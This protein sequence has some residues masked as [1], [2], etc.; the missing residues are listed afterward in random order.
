MSLDE[1]RHPSCHWQPAQIAKA[2]W[3]GVFLA[4]SQARAQPV[5]DAPQELLFEYLQSKNLTILD[6]GILDDFNAHF[7]QV[8]YLAS[9]GNEVK[10]DSL[11]HQALTV[12]RDHKVAHRVFLGLTALIG[13]YDVEK[14]RFRVLYPMYGKSGKDRGELFSHDP[15][16]GVP[17]IPGHVYSE[18][19][20]RAFTSCTYTPRPAQ[21]VDFSKESYFEVVSPC[22]QNTHQ[23]TFAFDAWR[24][25]SDLIPSVF[26]IVP[27]EDRD[28]SFLEMGPDD[29]E[30]LIDKLRPAQR[31]IWAEF[32]FDVLDMKTGPKAEIQLDELPDIT[33]RLEVGAEF[34]VRPIAMFAWAYRPDYRGRSWLSAKEPGNFLFAKGS[35]KSKG[36][37]PGG[38]ITQQAIADT[39]LSVSQANNVPRAAVGRK[40][41]V[42]RP[43]GVEGD[44]PPQQARD[45][46]SV[47]TPAPPS[48]DFEKPPGH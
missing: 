44:V 45:S 43:G 47:V 30:R 13:D 38:V 15:T 48:V 10:I 7:N 26:K 14:H 33:Q 46:P 29:A 12:I 28:W 37:P 32:V 39:S 31:Q 5:P 40:L 3:I 11:R 20:E 22:D 6:A 16:R 4:A 34:Q 25:V 21:Y 2:A 1:M 17:S 19:E 9:K 41:K 27:T 23:T 42:V 8:I 35:V 18:A 24:G 36:A